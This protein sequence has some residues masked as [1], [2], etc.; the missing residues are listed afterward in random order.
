M[1]L[2]NRSRVVLEAAAVSKETV[3]RVATASGIRN[4]SEVDAGKVMELM[5]NDPDAGV[6]K[7][8]AIGAEIWR[9]SAVFR[10]NTRRRD[11][12]TA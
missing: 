11:R 7:A 2:S 8:T 4:L 5:T 12:P 3:V 9:L 6:R 10:S 1:I